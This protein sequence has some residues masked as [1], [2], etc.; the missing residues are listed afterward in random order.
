LL[1]GPAERA[2][3]IVDFRGLPNGTVIRMTNTAPD[4]PFGGFPDV[5]SDPGTTGQVMQFVVNTALLG[6]SPS[7]EK[8]NRRGQFTP[9]DTSATSPWDLMLSPIEGGTTSLPLAAT[10]RNLVLMEEESALVCADVDAAGNLVQLFDY[11]PVNGVCV[12]TV[13]GTPHATALPFAPKAAVL[14][15]TDAAGVDSVTLWSDPIASSP[16][17]NMAEVWNI[18]NITADAHP[19]HVH[20]V[21]YKVISRTDLNGGP[22]PTVLQ[23][24]GVEAWEHGWK[25][26]VITY[27]NGGLGEITTIQ[28]DF[29]I[30]GLYVWHCHILEHEDNEMMVPFCVGG[31]QA[32]GG[33]CPDKLF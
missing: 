33:V 7:D 8:R 24:N 11:L 1:M 31:S 13:D 15:T 25:D 2:D 32:N 23:P 22:S 5:P 17:L 26:T 29:D 28:A 19:I 9:D 27:P 4:A 12:S 10:P 21:K 14:G 18:K 3:I 20:L 16:T 6:T 30:P